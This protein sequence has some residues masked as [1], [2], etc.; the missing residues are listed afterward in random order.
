[1]QKVASREQLILFGEEKE[2]KKFGKD[3]FSKGEREA[4][5]LVEEAAEPEV[6]KCACAETE[7]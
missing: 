2:P 1:M 3:F 6:H 4:E 7:G 5:G